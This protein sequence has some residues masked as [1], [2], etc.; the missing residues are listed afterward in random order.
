MNEFEILLNLAKFY[1]E[2]FTTIY[3]LNVLNA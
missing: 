2:K 3:L 1:K